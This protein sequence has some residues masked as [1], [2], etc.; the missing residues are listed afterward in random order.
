MGGVA[1]WNG[2]GAVTRTGLL[3]PDGLPFDQWCLAWQALEACQGAIQWWLGDCLQYGE[4]QYGEEFAQVIGPDRS[5]QTYLNLKWVAS[6]FAPSRRRENLS[7]SHHAEVA[8]C[9]PPEQDAWLNAAEQHEWSRAEL[10]RHMREFVP[11]SDLPT[12]KTISHG[13]REWKLKPAG[14][15]RAVDEE[16][17]PGM[18]CDCKETRFEV[19]FYRGVTVRC[20]ACMKNYTLT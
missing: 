16:A 18:L 15:W 3:L 10:R 13:D 8:A 17:F 20:I 12:A 14:Y 2:P 5:P 19:G 4:Q 1:V 6:R 11:E 9:E 7:W